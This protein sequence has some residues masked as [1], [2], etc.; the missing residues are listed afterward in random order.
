MM[1]TSSASTYARM[2]AV[3]PISTQLDKARVRQKPP[4]WAQ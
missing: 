1:A 4:R 3:S 2:I